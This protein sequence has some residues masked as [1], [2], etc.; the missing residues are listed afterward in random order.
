MGYEMLFV[1]VLVTVELNQS[2]REDDQMWMPRYLYLLHHI[3]ILHIFIIFSLSLSGSQR[4]WSLSQL[5]EGERRG[6]TQR[7]RQS[8]AGETETDRQ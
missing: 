1:S 3:N 7:G 5:S 4:S 6:T 2:V 8:F